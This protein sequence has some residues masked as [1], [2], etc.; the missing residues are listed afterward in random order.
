MHYERWT[1]NGE[2]RTPC[3]P[4]AVALQFEICNLKSEIETFPLS[5]SPLHALFLFNPSP[6]GQTVLHALQ[7]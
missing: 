5:A 7:T 1:I 3:L 4:K 6:D 2:F